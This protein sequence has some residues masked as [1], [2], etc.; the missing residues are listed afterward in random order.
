MARRKKVVFFIPPSIHLLDLSGP[1]QAFVLADQVN[2]GYE[3]AYCSFS[4]QGFDSSG[5]HFCQLQS[6]S[7]VKLQKED[8]LF[9]PGFSTRLLSGIGQSPE[10]AA[11]F[12]WL[13]TQAEM[14]V[15]ICSVCVGAFVL[16]E[17]GLLSGKKCTTHW[18]LIRLLK[19]SFPQAHVQEDC[20]F[21]NDGN[22][23]SSAGISAGIDL[24]LFI[25]EEEH[26]A[27]FAHKIARE[28]VVYARRG[29]QHPQESI[30]LHYRNHLHRG[31]HELQ[32]WLIDHLDTKTTIGKMAALVNMSSRNLTRIFKMQTGV[33]IQQYITLLRLEKAKMLS[34]SPGM[35]ISA[36][37]RACGF[38]N[39]R[40]LQ[41][42]RRKPVTIKTKDH[43]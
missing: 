31:I 3:I 1:S 7:E 23:Y 27:L 2:G 33:T 35:T 20:L 29:G 38:E 19:T 12:C 5:L 26:G 9:I 16:A 18:K 8:Y 36:I 13:R 4:T 25:L 24:A 21:I 32:D 10:W 41:R 43:A 14:G 15:R 37:A 28:L 22:I 39:E 30:Y 17:A 40:Q 42:I 6:F 34:H 11:F